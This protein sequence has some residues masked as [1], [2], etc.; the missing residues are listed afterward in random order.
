MNNENKIDISGLSKSSV[1]A[2]LYNNAKPQGIGLLHYEQKD[3]T[4]DEAQKLL[5]TGNR[6]FDYVKG[7]VMK[8]ELSCDYL[9][10][11]L[12][13][14]DNGKGSAEYVINELKEK[15]NAITKN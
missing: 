12:Y 9:D 4:D 11:R 10:P 3:M 1:L 15:Q 5:D 13:D 2:A 6:Y 14:R 8:V 7:R